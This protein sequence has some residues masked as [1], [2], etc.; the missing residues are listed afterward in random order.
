MPRAARPQMSNPLAAKSWVSY[1]LRLSESRL[2]RA[3][4]WL[5]L[6]NLLT[7]VLGYVYQVLMGRMLTPADFALF[8]AIMALFMFTASPLGAM[9]MVISRRVST[10]RA[11]NRLPMLRNLYWRTHQ[12]LAIIAG[13]FLL[14]LWLV[15]TPLQGW[16]KAPDTQPLWLFGI[17]L[18]FGAFSTVNN[19]LFQGLQ[20]FGWL[21][22]TAIASLVL[23]IGLSVFL[24]NLGW[25]VGGA[26]YGVLLSAALVW[27]VGLVFIRRN[28]PLPESASR[29]SH[30]PFLLSTWLPVLI[31]NVA[32]AAMT[33]LDM[34]LVKAFFTPEQAGLYAAA[35]VLGKAV[36]YLPG[37]LV[38][39][40]FPLVA[41]NHAR[42]QSSAS[43][44]VQALLLVTVFSGV[45]ALAYWFL[46]DTIIAVFYGPAYAGAGEILRWY[47]LAIA[48]LA[49]VLVAENFLI[50]KGRVL[51]AW[52]FLALAPVQIFAI[53]FWHEEL[54]Q[55][56][57]IMG[58]CGTLL[59][60]I[61]YGFMWGDVRHARL[62]T[63]FQSKSPSSHAPLR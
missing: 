20:H 62:T 10:L 16:L 15:M 22:C 63:V 7:G 57:A 42:D 21:G 41:D 33:Q 30:E 52:L 50:A 1:A 23:K 60:L 18:V 53:A 39:A 43:L 56:M 31:A 8:T 13:L 32:F 12:V 9:F 49:L 2:L 51:F 40:L 36:L 19:A 59:V 58:C 29:L 3:G 17:I 45:G 28:L 27:I 61:G 38:W 14:S 46:G 34:V 26:L 4:F 48:P 55:V 5:T 44:M 37:G 35:S 24:I 47:G 6:A 11:Q 25:A 54:W